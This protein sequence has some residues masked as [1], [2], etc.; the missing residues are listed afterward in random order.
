M[1]YIC[2]SCLREYYASGLN[3]EKS[4][5]YNYKCPS[6]HCGD[7][8]VVEVDDSIMSTIKELNKKGYITKFCCSGHSY[9]DN[10]NTYISFDS[11][12]VPST[13]PND[14]IL[15][16]MDYYI[17]N[18]WS[19]IGD[20]VCIRKWYKD[21]KNEDLPRALLQTAIDLLDWVKELPNIKEEN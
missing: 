1:G 10:T 8:E 19:Y 6:I 15:E 2:T 20:Q 9:E 5:G 11:D 12:A 18:N 13:L 7:L 3:L 14:F 21:I 16:D 17:K 4:Y